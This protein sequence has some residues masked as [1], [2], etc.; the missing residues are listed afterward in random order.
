MVLTQCGAS[1]GGPRLRRNE[2]RVA[3]EARACPLKV[4]REQRPARASERRVAPLDA[5]P[6]PRD[7]AAPEGRGV[8]PVAAPQRGVER[9]R[10][11]RACERL[12]HCRRF[13]VESRLRRGRAA[14]LGV[15]RAVPRPTCSAARPTAAA[16][17]QGAA[18]LSTGIDAACTTAV[19][20][21]APCEHPAAERARHEELK[22]EEVREAERLALFYA[23]QGSVDE[24]VAALAVEGDVGVARVVGKRAV[25]CHRWE[26][27]SHERRGQGGF[28]VLRGVALIR[29][30]IS[31]SN[32]NAAHGRVH[33]HTLPS[34]HNW[35]CGRRGA[36]R[37]AR[38]S[39]PG[40][41]M[42]SEAPTLPAR[43]PPS[44]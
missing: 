7:A 22:P 35:W 24:S 39:A 38:S 41:R 32:P 27:V 9:H 30:P 23:A 12:L 8:R 3:R 36:R 11:E 40:D 17:R 20:G 15:P 16:A 18:V 26:V 25:H 21:L 13:L 5:A 6:Q 34:C 42:S 44:R 29:H 28:A 4:A 10:V 31:V 2:V 19:E 37:R 1:G 43:W 33:C 14:T